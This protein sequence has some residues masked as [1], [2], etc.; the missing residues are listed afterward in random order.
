M[1]ECYYRRLEADGDYQVFSSTKLTASG[2]GPN[3]QHGSPPMALLLKAIEELPEPHEHLRIGRVALDILGPIPLEAVRVRAWIERPG[4]RIAL[5]V[6]EMEA[7]AVGGYRPVARA[8]AWL[9]ATSVTADVASN[10]YAPLPEYP[11]G[12]RPPAFDSPGY[13]KSVDFHWKSV[14]GDEA[15][16][17]WMRAFTHIVDAEATTPLQ[18]LASCID[19]ANGIGAV[20]NPLRF[21]FM[22]T[23]TVM[24]LHRVP[25]GDEFGIRARMSVGPDGVGV[26]NAEI[27]DHHGFIGTSAQSVLVQRR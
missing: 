22:N 25:Q 21:V 14:P 12:A 7:P 20:L 18:R 27:F 8:S 3:L 15:R 4:R 1:S 13:A 10:R 23:D 17:A 9:L 6:A 11:D 26:T 2:W 24:H 5:A 16:V 19:S